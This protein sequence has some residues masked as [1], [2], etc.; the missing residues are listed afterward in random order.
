MY[1]KTLRLTNSGPID[2]LNIN[3][4]F[5]DA[6][7][8]VPVIL[9]G[10]NGSGKSIVLS[11]IV[12]AIISAQGIIFDDSDVEKGKV[13]KLRSPIYIKAGSQYS[14]GHVA[15]DNEYYVS[16]IQLDKLKKDFSEPVTEY[17]NWSRMSDLDM[18]H[19]SSNAHEKQDSLRREFGRSV[20]L[21][22]P[23]N[24]FE[25]PAWLNELNLANKS[26]YLTRRNFSSLSERPIIVY[27]PLRKIQS[28]LL[29]LIYDSLARER[30]VVLSKL[31]DGAS[32]RIEIRRGEATD[33]LKI[34]ETV[35][36][37][38]ARI[39]AGSI[40]WSVGERT[41]R[42]IGLAIDGQPFSNNLFSLSTGQTALLDLFLSIVM[43]FDI[44]QVRPRSVDSIRGIVVVD[45]VDLHLH[46]D[47]QHDVLPK[48][49]SVFPNVQF[50]VTTHSPMF[51]M[52]LAKEVGESGLQL[53]EL[54]TGNEIA[55]E[56]F[57]EFEVAYEHLKD[58]STFQKEIRELIEAARQ[59]LL[60]LEGATD[61]DYL[62]AA[63]RR[64]GRGGTLDRFRL[65]DAVGK[66]HLDKIWAAYHAHLYTS[67]HEL[68]ILLYD[69]DTSINEASAGNIFR[70][71]IP[72]RESPIKKGIENLFCLDTL[73]R[74][75]AFKP[76]FID[77][78]ESHRRVERGTAIVV[79]ECWSVNK[80]EKRNLCDWL[81]ENG[82][83]ED[84][85][86]FSVVFD[87]LDSILVASND[88]SHS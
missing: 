75:I 15:F 45:E 54:P 78:V 1:L 62:R 64:L 36:R 24:R 70:R 6:G 61:I 68:W 44:S 26:D 47:L 50:I 7:S 58:S 51:L 32:E 2:S 12:S 59:P 67:V 79:P 43:N 76:D 13:Y 81:C 57:S 21:H 80:D 56:R 27:S 22:F 37:A 8:P 14:I 20:F 28:W 17:E 42:S 34:V 86:G 40:Q 60:F 11:H 71:K 74:A 85:G 72:S 46:I 52:G 49:I 10:R 84:F 48:L 55:V 18:S 5:T 4:R 88:V 23:P 63:A 53:V 19:Y 82:S 16:E 65:I 73:Q 69:C 39:H 3:C 35:V 66:P 83:A 33:L 29:D 77:I 41:Q 9:V 25:E 31:V 87:I 30:V 38:I